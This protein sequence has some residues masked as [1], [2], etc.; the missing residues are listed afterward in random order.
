MKHVEGA[1]HRA[2]ISAYLSNNPGRHTT[3]EVTAQLPGV[4]ARTAGQLLRHMAATGLI[5]P[6]EREGNKK[7]WRW[8]EEREIV[9]PE[10]VTKRQAKPVS[11]AKEIEL[12]LGGLL[13]I[14]GKNEKTGRIRI[15]L[16]E[17]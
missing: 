1:Q 8:K 11:N 13:V 14:V 15:T 2:T 7:F 9:V 5:A 17:V 4:S 3:E 12:L 10:A 6:M 16:E